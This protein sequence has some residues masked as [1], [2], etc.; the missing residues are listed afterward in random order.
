MHGGSSLYYRSLGRWILAAPLV[1]HH[2]APCPSLRGVYHDGG[3]GCNPMGIQRDVS[4]TGET[5]DQ[6]Q[7][8]TLGTRARVPG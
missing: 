1:F 7:E 8:G 2:K 4:E 3:D 5:R 6:E